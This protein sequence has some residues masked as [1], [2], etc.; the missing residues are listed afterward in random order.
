MA[1]KKDRR[2]GHNKRTEEELLKDRNWRPER[3]GLPDA[4]Q[5][6]EPV[7]QMPL[8]EHGKQLWD[9]VLQNLPQR[10]ISKGDGYKLSMACSQW[11]QLQVQMAIWNA[12]PA[13]RDARLAVSQLTSSIDRLLSQFGMSPKD[14][15]R[16]PRAGWEQEPETDPFAEFLR[17]GMN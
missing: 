3:H 10:A 13:N 6:G 14:R 15:Q 1:A 16:M 5:A 9:E 7:P 17:S 12:D 2:G 8:G 11:D 4:F